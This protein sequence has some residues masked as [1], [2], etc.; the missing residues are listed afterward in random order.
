MRF[1][2]PVIATILLGMC[3]SALAQIAAS[4]QAQARPPLAALGPVAPATAA[5]PAAAEPLEVLTKITTV[6]ATTVKRRIDLPR[7]NTQHYATLLAEQAIKSGQDFSPAQFIVLVDRNP[8]V[9]TVMIFWKDAGKPETANYTL[10]GTTRTTTGGTPRFDHYLTPVGVFAHTIDN[11]DF[12]AEGTKNENGVRGYG[13]QGDRIY[14]LGWQ[15]TTKAWGKPEERQIRMQMHSTDPDLLEQRL[16]TIGSKGC[17]RIPA[18]F[19]ALVDRFGLIDADYNAAAQRGPR[20]WVWHADHEAT[21]YAGRYIV[22]VDS[23]VTEKPEWL[24]EKSAKPR[25]KS[26]V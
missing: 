21:P 19:N 8:L 24:M 12:R 2:K 20:P 5:A 17:V 16:G 6:F 10:I 22:I 23:N 15:T 1:F 4:P 13:K 26:S 9:Q 18:A 11:P 25:K 7:T 3:A 14:D